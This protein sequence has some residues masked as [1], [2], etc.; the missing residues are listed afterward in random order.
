MQDGPSFVRMQ[1][2]SNFW[3]KEDKKQLEKAISWDKG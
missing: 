2:W 3:K 1:G